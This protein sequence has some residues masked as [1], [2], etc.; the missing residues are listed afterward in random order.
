MFVSDLPVVRVIACAVLRLDLE[1]AAER[2]GVRLD[3]TLLPGG[4]HATPRDL[5][6]RLQEAVD[7]VSSEAAGEA[8]GAAGQAG[9]RVPRP[10]AIGYGVCGMG[11]AGIHARGVPLALPRVHDCIALFLGSDA[12][13]RRQFAA[14]PGTYYISAGWVDGKS[15]PRAAG[16]LTDQQFAEFVAR[17][18]AENTAAIRDFFSSW[19]KH[20]RRS[21]FIDTGAGGDK[22]R[23][24]RMARD[25][26]GEL[27]WRYERLAGSTDLL[28]R[29]L[30]ETVSG[31][32]ILVVPPG[33]VTAYDAAGRRLTAVAPETGES[34]AGRR[35]V[36]SRQGAGEARG[37]GDASG[38]AS[39]GLGIDAG[40]TYT[41]AVVYDFHAAALLGKAKAPTTRWDYA[42][43]IGEA[44]AGLEP[45]LLASVDLVALST[46]FATNAIVEGRG[47]PV[48]LLVMP[49]YGRFDPSRFRHHPIAADQGAARDRRDRAGSPDIDE[50][51]AAARDMVERHGVRAFAVAGY[52]SHNNPAHELAVKRA[53]REETGLGVTC[54]HE[55]SDGLNYRIRAETAALNARI[56]PL[57][58]DLLGDVRRVLAERGIG[59]PV[60]VVRSDGS[61]MSLEA[62][63]ERPIE[64]ALSGP[65][66]SVAG[67]QRLTGLREALVVDMGGT[68]SDTARIADGI[69]E[70]RRDGATIGGWKTHVRALAMRTL[71]LG[72][73]SLIRLE[74]GDL[75][76]GPH[77]VLPVCSLAARE[78][79]TTEALLWLERHADAFATSTDGST[80]LA[81][82]A[83]ARAPDGAD[84]RER[85]LLEA[86]A[87]RP[88]SLHELASVL[89]VPS[90][91]L[92]SSARLEERG[93]VQ[94]CSLTPTDLLHA[95]G[96][97]D[98]WDAAAASRLCALFALL[99]HAGAADF[100]ARGL[101]E[102]ERALAAEL[103]RMQLE[104]AGTDPDGDRSPMVRALFDG[105]LGRA[106]TPGLSIGIRLD[107]P[108]VGIGAPVHQFL[109]AAAALLGTRAVVPA[110]ADVA[111]AIGAIT[112]SV[113]VRR[114]AR[115]SVDETGVYRV[116]GL[117]ERPGLRR[118][119][120]RR[121]VR[122]R[123]AARDRRRGRPARGHAQRHRRDPQHGPDQRGRRRVA[124]VPRP[125]RG[126]AA[127]GGACG[128]AIEVHGIPRPPRSGWHDGQKNV[129]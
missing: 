24:E 86:L 127:A 21:A 33:H 13:Y 123:A 36:A 73:D 54:G 113:V 63:F 39:R 67:A 82:S 37:S 99:A 117:P 18:G 11:A 10:I 107:A 46:T 16:A 29:L 53:I 65:A 59:A 49:P 72:G 35:L 31:D 41:D 87:R 50:V 93:I 45:R 71:G 44:L 51:K 69:V 126:G 28:V 100:A 109:P 85:R 104:A 19:Q 89:D 92:L 57:L 111:N 96:R 60:M 114:E 95:A 3:L 2:A 90:W 5:R 124:R 70:V 115:I 9:A 66:A 34:P 129:S 106:A 55:V 4:L 58:E 40:G 103:L 119:V 102:V 120:G 25:M 101:R 43:G 75:A 81:L 94:R 7:E 83:G 108:V 128:L 84:E 47:Q 15:Q 26:A 68:T 22:G 32:E 8:S 17:Y 30:T 20:Y 27:G 80:I 91:R 112:G 62:A 38:R 122:G 121:S 42:V 79:R 88:H 125:D 1:A 64:T 76:I 23:Y 6:L 78:P 48:G 118:P 56:I 77:R 116:R 52:A 97:M 110:N 61:L 12:A 74:K 98:L 105:A 14:C